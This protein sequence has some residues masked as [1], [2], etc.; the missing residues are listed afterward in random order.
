VGRPVSLVTATVIE[1]FG[2]G[3]RFATFL[4]PASLGVL[5]GGYALTFAALGL[6]STAGVSFSLIRRLREVAWV[7]VGLLALALTRPLSIRD[8]TRPD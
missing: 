3:I 7:A 2:T 1:A 5:E 4:I 8:P 6:G